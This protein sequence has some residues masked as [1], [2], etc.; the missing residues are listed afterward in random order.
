MRYRAVLGTDPRTNPNPNP[1]S[2]RVF[3]KQLHQKPCQ[4]LKYHKPIQISNIRVA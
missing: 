4:A 3:H 2:N 1:N